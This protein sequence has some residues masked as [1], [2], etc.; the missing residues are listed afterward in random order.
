MDTSYKIIFR[1]E[2]DTLFDRDGNLSP[3]KMEHLAMVC[4]NL[5]NAGF[6]VLIVSSGAIMLGTAKMGLSSPPVE[7]VEKQAIAA[8]GQAD[9]INNYQ[10]FF[11]TFDQMVAQVL[12]TRDVEKNTTRNK[13]A[14]MTLH[15]LM[16]KNIIPVINENDSVSTDDIILN[17]NYPLTLIVAGLVK[18]HAIVVKSAT[19]GIYQLLIRNRQAVEEINEERLFH[20]ANTLKSGRSIAT[21]IG[22][23]CKTGKSLSEVPSEI[24][25]MKHGFPEILNG[26]EISI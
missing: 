5:S 7:L 1:I 9:L 13:N 22:F 12:L 19:E 18:P 25:K 14:R 15:R 21:E 26:K 3:S 4:T 23:D 20:L 24:V 17:D 10:R 8:I 2:I 6:R 16:E 11:E